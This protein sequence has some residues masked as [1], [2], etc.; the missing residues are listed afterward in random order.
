MK[1]AGALLLLLLSACG[2][3]TPASQREPSETPSPSRA[4]P[5]KAQSEEPKRFD[6]LT[7]TLEL[8]KTTIP[9]DGKV[10]STFTVENNS[11]EPVVDPSCWLGASSS[12][13][14]PVSEPDAELGFQIVVDCGGPRTM[15]V[16]FKERWTGP[17]FFGRTIYGEPLAP[18]DYYAAY[19]IRGLSERIL[20]PV[21]VE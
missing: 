15:G 20:V 2:D 11:D 19:E 1:L 9:S 13:V 6:D 16:G 10:D 8:E 4:A 3:P 5:V 21:T 7:L 14:I 12:G 17:E 18:G